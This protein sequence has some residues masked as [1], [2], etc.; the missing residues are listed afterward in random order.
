MFGAL[1]GGATLAVTVFYAYAQA[2]FPSAV[3]SRFDPRFLIAEVGAYLLWLMLVGVVFMAF[4]V[5]RADA[6][7]RIAEALDTRPVANIPLVAGRVFG[8]VA[9]AAL[10]VLATLAVV[11][12]LGTVARAMDFWMGNPIEP[13]SLASFVLLDV[14]VALFVWAATVM[15]LSA[16]LRNRLAVVA[17]AA[18]LLAL[19]VWATSTVPAYLLPAISVVSTSVGWASDITPEFADLDRLLQRF[20][21]VVLGI[22]ICVLAAAVHPRADGGSRSRRAAGGIAIVV[23]AL[24][25]LGVVAGRGVAA[26]EQREE[27]LAVH[28]AAAALEASTR[29]DVERIAGSIEIDPGNSLGIDIDMHLRVAEDGTRSWVFSFNP[30]MRVIDLE[31]GG[32]AV[33]FV[34][35]SGLL[36]I[37]GGERMSGGSVVVSLRAHGVPDPDFGYLDSVADWRHRP[38]TNLLKYLGR[39]ASLYH[40]NY[41]AL[42]P[43]VHWLPAPGA[44]V[45][46]EDPS[47]RSADFFDLD[48]AVEVPPGWAVAGPGR[49]RP[50]RA[51]PTRHAF[52]PTSPVREVALFASAFASVSRA[53]QGIELELLLS[54]KHLPNLG[55]YAEAGSEV[56]RHLTEMF[57]GLEDRGLPYSESTLTMVEVPT[58]LRTYRGGWRLDPVRAPGVLLLREEGLPTVSAGYYDNP[59]RGDTRPSDLALDLIIYF[60]NDRGSGNAFQGLAGQI[61][62]STSP[63]GPGAVA[64]DAITRDLAYRVLNPWGWDR[65][66]WATAHRFDRDSPFGTSA[67]DT[68]MGVRTGRVGS[69][70]LALTMALEH[71]PWDLLGRSSLVG[72]DGGDDPERSFGVMARR[73][74]ALEGIVLDTLG[75]GETTALLGE[76]R[77]RHEGS[78]YT[79]GDFLAVAED[80]KTGLAETLDDAMHERGLPGFLASAA[81]VIRISDDETGA[82]RYHVSVHVQNG[83]PVVGWLRLARYDMWGE[84]ESIRVPGNSSVEIGRI[85]DTPPDQLW[86]IPYLSLNR[87]EM[88]LALAADQPRPSSDADVFVGTRPSAWVPREVDGIVVDDLDPGFAW[89]SAPARPN[90]WS[91]AGRYRGVPDTLDHG[92]PVH[93]PEAGAWT[94]HD[95]PSAWGKYRRTVA[96]AG[97]GDGDYHVSFKAALAPGR[98]RL[99][100]YLPE[101]RIPKRGPGGVE[102]WLYPRVGS[103][104]MRLVVGQPDRQDESHGDRDRGLD[105]DAALGETGW[106]KLGEFDLPG[107]EVRL[108]IDNRTTGA[109][110]IADAIRWRPVDPVE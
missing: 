29:V 9:A 60:L 57:S 26:V 106:N 96:W 38:A 46:R 25:G 15:L 109:L 78:T 79:L 110:V 39:K 35:E 2:V 81:H 52:R 108:V 13:V 7:A 33:S 27:W 73:G 6:R 94:R 97:A 30:G 36:T 22:G 69:G 66:I 82:P 11:Q 53:V 17:V 28:R 70:S 1:A 58:S 93:A 95:V 92:L 42:T 63:T 12:V 43:A 105:F 99:D 104:A 64:L 89:R 101:Q 40:P 61:L 8:V 77:R 80:A 90:R 34:H 74:N 98:W 44:N 54:P 14:L 87:R 19:Q 48:L 32:E 84:G 50:Q 72:I 86:L 59:T 3:A 47:K 71:D 62:G 91:L 102:R 16:M 56:E 45:H 23:L 103:M 85:Y 41:V 100:Y 76:L 5:R 10:P 4:D 75:I 83:E 18:A 24:V 37:D 21:V 65:S 107:G 55:Y 49:Q 88:R 67:F 68:I 20:A 51:T 31:V